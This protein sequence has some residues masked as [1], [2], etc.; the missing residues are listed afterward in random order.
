[1]T[2]GELEKIKK[3][4]EEFFEKM[5]IEAEIE[6]KRPQDSTL[7]I[8]LKTKEPQLLIGEGGQTLTEI[9]RLLKIILKRKISPQAPFYVDLDINDYKKKKIGYLKELARSTADEVS[10]SKEE[11]QLPPMPAHERRIIHLELAERT[12]VVA[13]SI[14]QEPERKIVISPHL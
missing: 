4:I 3:S 12:D 5:T 7:P 2:R 9:Q 14:G 11:K 8:G 6:V 1:M 10:L 13:E